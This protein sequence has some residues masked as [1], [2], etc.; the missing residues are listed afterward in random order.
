MP[1]PKLPLHLTGLLYPYHSWWWRK[2]LKKNPAVTGWNYRHNAIFVHIPKTAGSSVLEALGAPIVF[3]THAPSGA[4]RHRYPELYAS[5]Y[6]FAF[7]RNPWDR[8]ASS[9]H[10]MK[11]GTTWSL[12]R[13]WAKAHIGELDFAGFT[14]RLRQPLYRA[15]IM[16]E[17]FFWPQTVWTGGVGDTSGVDAIF[18]FEALDEAVQTLCQRFQ[19]E[20]PARTPH[21]RKVE[22]PDFRAL[23]DD[24]MVD[25]VGR[26]YR[27]DIAALGYSFSG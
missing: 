25:I 17:R 3:D 4:Y 26:L 14:R 27:R 2:A 9:F 8:F 16:S 13:D 6:K 1:V 23:Y 5:A 15:K 11:H 10:F 21:L 18:R 12:Q 20:A 19:I 24:E 22:R 7:V